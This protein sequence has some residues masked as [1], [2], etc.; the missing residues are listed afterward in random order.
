MPLIE[1]LKIGD[2]IV[3]KDT[4]GKISYGIVVKFAYKGYRVKKYED[5][6]AEAKRVEQCD[7][8]RR[9]TEE[10]YNEVQ[11]LVG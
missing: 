7:V 10:E 9:M 1:G 4:K 11:G 5:E 6:S 2:G 8:I 3:V